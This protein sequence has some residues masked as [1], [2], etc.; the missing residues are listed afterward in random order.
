MITR[1]NNNKEVKE[2][3]K[4]IAINPLGKGTEGAVWLT[5]NGDTIKYIF[6]EARIP[7]NTNMLTEDELKL[8][9]FIFPTEILVEN[10]FVA[11]YRAKYFENDLFNRMN[12]KTGKVINLENLLE[13]R[14]KMAKDLYNLTKAKYEIEDIENNLMFD[15]KELKAIDTL[16]YHKNYNIQFYD[17]LE[18]LDYA[19]ISRLILINPIVK[20][21]RYLPA[22]EVINRLMDDDIFELT[23]PTFGRKK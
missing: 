13:A 12:E 23:I 2:Y 17:N 20:R 10:T 7:Y 14:E 4:N 19:I 6:K 5:E 15:G 1:L 11:G 9:S 22:D 3:I 8:D 18:K 16:E 21:M